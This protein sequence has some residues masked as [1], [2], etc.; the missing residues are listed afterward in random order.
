LTFFLTSLFLLLVIQISTGDVG[1]WD[2]LGRLI[3]IDRV[4]NI[5]KLAQGEYIAPEKIEAV[6]AKHHLVA[7]V[8][9]YGHSLKATLVGV[10]VPDPDALKIWADENGL[11]GKSY[12]E[13]CAEPSVKTF[14]LKDLAVFGRA[15]DLKGFE[16][17]KNIYVVSEQFSIEND[18][19]VRAKK[20][21]LFVD[22]STF[23]PF[24]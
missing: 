3:V 12:E 24:A 2:D 23:F 16:I 13:L 9:V 4:K 15:S 20:M 14:L 8:F 18:L 22:Q 5:F 10:V 21:M 7:Q 11:G 17:L 6:L 19:M 1:Q